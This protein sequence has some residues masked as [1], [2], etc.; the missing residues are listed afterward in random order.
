MGLIDIRRRVIANSPHLATAS[1]AI[2]TFNTK[3]AAPLAGLTANVVLVQ[4]GSGDPSPSNVRSISGWTG[5]RIFRTKKNLLNPAN[6]DS[7]R[8]SVSDGVYTFTLTGYVADLMSG[9]AGGSHVIP[10]EKLPNLPVLAPGTYVWSYKY[11]SGGTPGSVWAV[12]E[13]GVR[14]TTSP[15]QIEDGT[16]KAYRFTLTKSSRICITRASNS[17]PTIFS[18]PQIELGTERTAY[19]AYNGDVYPVSWQTEAG[20]VYG[21]TLNTVTGVLTVTDANISSYAG[22]ELPGAWIS[23]RDVYSQGGTPT[24]GAQVVYKLAEPYTVQLT[25]VQITTL[26]G[27]N[28]IWADTGDVSVKYWA[29]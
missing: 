25:P 8:V 7:N 3:I 6:F 20:T 11:T 13:N 10:S 5:C 27:E 17:N 2:V 15:T 18:E 9:Q 22:E 4:D 28:N 19:E 29:L 26:V 12:D 23:D 21:G 1:G 16:Y 24:T 14:T